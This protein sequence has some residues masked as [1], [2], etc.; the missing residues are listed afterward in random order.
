LERLD[1]SSNSI[2]LGTPDVLNAFCAALG[3]SG[4][5]HVD[6]SENRFSGVGATAL[7]HVVKANSR[8]QTLGLKRNRIGSAGFDALV[9]GVVA[10]PGCQLTAC[11][12]EDNEIGEDALLRGAAKLRQAE[13]DGGEPLVVRVGFNAKKGF[14]LENARH[15]TFVS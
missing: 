13:K 5:V 4:L 7:Q 3:G 6:L 2:G 9:E 10:T 8:L 14:V 1:L 15:V 11:D 12:V